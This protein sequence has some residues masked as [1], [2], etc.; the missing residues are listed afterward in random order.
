LN[1]IKAKGKL[2]AKEHLVWAFYLLLQERIDDSIKIFKMINELFGKEDVKEFQLQYDYFLAY[3][4]L[5]IGGDSNNP[6]QVAK[7]ICGK[8]IDYQVISWRNMFIDLANY[9]EGE[10]EEESTDNT[11]TMDK[12]KE[13]NVVKQNEKNAKKEEQLLLSLFWSREE[14]YPVLEYDNLVET[15]VKLKY[16]D[17]DMEVAYSNS[18]FIQQSNSV[19]SLIKPNAIEEIH[20]KP[21]ELTKGKVNIVVPK[22]LRGK[23]VWIFASTKE[24]TSSLLFNENKIEVLVYEEYG[25][26]K[27]VNE[28]GKPLP[29]VYIK[30]YAKS[31]AAN[32]AFYKDGYTDFLGRFEYMSVSSG[33]KSKDDVVKL[34][35]YV[36]SNDPK[37]ELIKEV[38]PPSGIGKVD[39]EA[40]QAKQIK[41]KSILLQK[42]KA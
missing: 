8:Y 14:Q 3:L 33:N 1:Y 25:Q 42:K 35:I 36:K 17:I 26:L 7:E 16:Y 10:E 21:E 23:N 24:K 19:Y 27:V 32:V 2:S 30:V 31:K 15:V 5:F 20:I 9:L 34:A 6:Y 28:D 41:S 4:D 11:I 40:Y 37:G 38:N 12:S 29:K 13:V 18:P 22:E 39:T